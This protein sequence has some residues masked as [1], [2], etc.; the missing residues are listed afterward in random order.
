MAA[1]RFPVWLARA[2]DGRLL[3]A[4]Q[5]SAGGNE[6]S[7]PPLKQITANFHFVPRLDGRSR[8]R[9]KDG[10]NFAL[11]LA[12]NYRSGHIDCNAAMNVPHMR[13]NAASAKLG[14]SRS[15]L[16]RTAN[17]GLSHNERQQS[18]LFRPAAHHPSEIRISRALSS[19][20]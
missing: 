19:P 17:L 4:F 14:N 8:L 2:R 7:L 5:L 15:V 1:S 16:S 6:R 18:V 3:P 11:R 12:F 20:T 9:R 10:L 13:K